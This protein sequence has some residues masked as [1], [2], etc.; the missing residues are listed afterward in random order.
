MAHHVK[1]SF[2]A[3][4]ARMPLFDKLLDRQENNMHLLSWQ[5]PIKANSI[6]YTIP[7]ITSEV[8]LPNTHALSPVPYTLDTF[9]SGLFLANYALKLFFKAKNSKQDKKNSVSAKKSRI[10]LISKKQRRYYPSHFIFFKSIL[11]DQTNYLQ[12]KTVYFL[13]L[14]RLISLG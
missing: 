10:K 4:K 13:S 14:E 9:N 11:D 7:T 1:N 12:E 8:P 5:S 2:Y 6:K 3:L